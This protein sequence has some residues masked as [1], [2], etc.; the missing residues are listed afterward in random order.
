MLDF[1]F[2][3]YLPIPKWGFLTAPSNPGPSKLQA[4]S[5]LNG[6]IPNG[7][8]Q[9]QFER[10]HLPSPSM[11]GCRFVAHIRLRTS[12]FSF[13]TPRVEV[14]PAECSA[15]RPGAWAVPASYEDPRLRNIAGIA[16]LI[17]RLNRLGPFLR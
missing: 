17:E 6:Q 11:Y 10:R 2:T 9:T 15:D 16:P 12:S 3:P 14:P 7:P 4:A 1:P 13:P 5:D 8:R